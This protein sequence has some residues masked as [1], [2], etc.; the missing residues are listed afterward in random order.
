[1]PIHL[2]CVCRKPIKVKD[3]L[4][5]KRIKCPAC[6]KRLNVPGNSCPGCGASLA[7]QAV[8]CVACGFNRKTG[9]RLETVRQAAGC[10][11]ET[12]RRCK[13]CGA[14]MIPDSPC[15]I[16][17]QLDEHRKSFRKKRRFKASRFGILGNALWGALGFLFL[18][19]VLALIPG[20]RGFGAVAVVGA[21]FILLYGLW[22]TVFGPNQS[23]PVRTIKTFIQAAAGVPE[24]FA[25]AFG[26]LTPLAQS[27]TGY[28]PEGF[29]NE[30]QQFALDQRFPGPADLG[31]LDEKD[32]SNNTCVVEFS[33]GDRHGLRWSLVC[34]KQKWYLAEFGLRSQRP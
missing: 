33:W 4:A 6:G 23:S 12:V 16:C 17:G 8:V 30:W 3:D 18:G 20:V 34:H 1:M 21:V 22:Q 29:G 28:S 31:T 9:K 32:L 14:K 10:A 13:D 11:P 7:A 24:N 27:N 26:C 25:V 19:V 2:T 5:G 15:T